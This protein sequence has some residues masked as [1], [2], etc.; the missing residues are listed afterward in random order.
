[1]ITTFVV[2]ILP[3]SRCM[4]S[5]ITSKNDNTIISLYKPPAAFQIISMRGAVKSSTLSDFSYTKED[6]SISSVKRNSLHNQKSFGCCCSATILFALS[7]SSSI[8]FSTCL[9]CRK[10]V[11]ERV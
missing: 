3:P 9:H 2:W 11:E 1:M 10:T 5:N 6:V 8:S 4:I 7:I